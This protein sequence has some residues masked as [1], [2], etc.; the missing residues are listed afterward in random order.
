MDRTID[1]RINS[2]S[3]RSS[4]LNRRRYDDLEHC[5]IDTAVK[6]PSSLR[7]SDCVGSQGRSGCHLVPLATTVFSRITSFRIVA[8]SATFFGLPAATSL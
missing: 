3:D 4:N 6:T 2:Q 8:V 5:S 1:L 7:E